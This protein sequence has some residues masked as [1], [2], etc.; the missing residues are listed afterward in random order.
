VTGGNADDAARV[1]RARRNAWLLALFAVACY[2]AFI[3]WSSVRG[4]Y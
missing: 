2:V 3:V 1:A 4:P